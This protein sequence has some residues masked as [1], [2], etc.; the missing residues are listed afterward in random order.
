MI[1]SDKLARMKQWDD[2]IVEEYSKVF[3]YPAPGARSLT[4]PPVKYSNHPT[5]R[6]G[7]MTF[8]KQSV[9]LNQLEQPSAVVS[10]VKQ[11]VKQ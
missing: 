3:D 7:K 1:R 9:G 2:M 10:S 5:P 8:S 11:S 4:P 6:T